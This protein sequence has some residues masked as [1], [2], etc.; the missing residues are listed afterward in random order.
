MTAE[1]RRGLRRDGSSRYDDGKAKQLW[2]GE[3]ALLLETALAHDTL[4]VLAKTIG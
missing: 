1:L 2:T 4:L 3:G